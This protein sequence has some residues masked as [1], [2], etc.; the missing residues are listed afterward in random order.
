MEVNNITTKIVGKRQKKDAE[1]CLDESSESSDEVLLVK[2][3]NSKK[4]DWSSAIERA[5][6]NEKSNR[7]EELDTLVK[8]ALANFSKI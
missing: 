7:K 4:I 6:H 1:R 8:G 2:L 5:K 3:V